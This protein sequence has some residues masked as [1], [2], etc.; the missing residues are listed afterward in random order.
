MR[1]VN[2]K[3]KK[4][5]LD[6]NKVVELYKTGQ[7]ATQICKEL[8]YSDIN[9][10]CSVLREFG[11][12]DKHRRKRS[13]DEKR[14]I[15]DY[16]ITKNYEA[17]AKNFN[18]SPTSVSQCVSRHEKGTGVLISETN[19][20]KNRN[21]EIIKLYKDGLSSVEIQKQFGYSEGV[22]FGA[23][24]KYEDQTGDII[25]RSTI[26]YDV[27]LD[28]FKNID[29]EA[30]AYHFG[31]ATS[32]GCN[33]GYGFTLFLHKKDVEI[34]ETFKKECGY[35]GPLISKQKQNQIGLTINR[36]EFVKNLER[37][38]VARRKTYCLE[39]PKFLPSN[40][41]RHFCRGH[42]EG[43]GTVGLTKN[44]KEVRA[45]IVSKMKNFLLD[46]KQIL[47][48]RIGIT[49]SVGEKKGKGKYKDNICYVLYISGNNNTL[50]FLDW[51]YEGCNF[52]L[53]RK[54]NTYLKAKEHIN[55]NIRRMPYRQPVLKLDLKENTLAKYE[56]TVLAGK[57]NGI[58]HQNIRFCCLNPNRTAGGFKWRFAN[59]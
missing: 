18:I 32:D 24:H 59:E 2:A 55:N 20:K 41:L 58:F 17:T 7:T 35:T 50:K 45:S 34:L 44:N 54:R 30:K 13:F 46:F 21:K 4:R 56:N 37:H 31:W 42:F 49:C 28:Y 43:D 36:Q 3:T 27:D 10:I 33:Q 12:F 39:F 15:D 1:S 25:T 5:D 38:G 19:N 48:E 52:F 40:L 57:E 26:K 9:Y 29:T 16:L 14:V 11:I 51:I 6:K 22:I 23:I 53:S 47:E 8:N